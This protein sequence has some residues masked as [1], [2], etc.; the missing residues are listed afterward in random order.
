MRNK[1]K[2]NSEAAEARSSQ[3][4]KQEKPGGGKPHREAEALRQKE[5]RCS[6]QQWQ[7]EEKAEKDGEALMCMH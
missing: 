6:W 5:R 1:A 4:Q 7:V 2:R 3:D